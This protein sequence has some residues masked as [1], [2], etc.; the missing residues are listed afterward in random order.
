M[1]LDEVEPDTLL[2]RS[3]KILGNGVIDDIRD[4]VVIDAQSF[5]RLRSPEAAL[6]VARFDAILRKQERPYLLIG[7]GRWGSTDPNL[8]IPVSW[9]QI[10]GARVIIESGFK[11]FR[12]APSQGTHFFQ[13]LTIGSVGYFTV[14]P[15]LEDGL[16]DWSWLADLPA[17]EGTDLVRHLRV[18]SPLIVKMSG[19]TSEGIILKPGN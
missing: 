14:N 16:L 9:N 11:D 15:D 6:D 12:V 17:V 18:E 10:T 19:K 13:N 1:V 8:G 4:L 5:E 3:S 7:V 2:C